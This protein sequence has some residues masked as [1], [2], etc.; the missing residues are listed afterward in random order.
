MESY[1]IVYTYMGGSGWYLHSAY[2]L[3]TLPLVR[4]QQRPGLLS[5][6]AGSALPPIKMKCSETPQLLIGLKRGTL[7]ADVLLCRYLN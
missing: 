6:Q 4:G 1:R 3:T 2:S 7:V 5:S